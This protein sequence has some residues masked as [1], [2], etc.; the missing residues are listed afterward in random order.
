MSI[1]LIS[2][3]RDTGSVFLTLIFRPWADANGRPFVTSGIHD[4]IDH[5]EVEVHA[6]IYRFSIS[7]APFIGYRLQKLV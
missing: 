6:V 2:N 7:I 1:K 3:A 4:R 5:L